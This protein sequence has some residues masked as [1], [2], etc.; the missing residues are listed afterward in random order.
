MGRVTPGAFQSTPLGIV[1]A[2]SGLTPARALLNYRQA[3]FT[4]WSHARSKD[5]QGLEGILTKEGAA[6]ALRRGRQPPSV[7]ETRP[8]PRGGA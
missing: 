1:A 8:R 4:Q 3:K 6:V 2:E 7:Q 5:G